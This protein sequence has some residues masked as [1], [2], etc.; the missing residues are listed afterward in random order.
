MGGHVAVPRG[1]L[2]PVG[3]HCDRVSSNLGVLGCGQQGPCR[4]ES[5]I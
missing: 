3:W 1:P 5:R 2:G 4:E